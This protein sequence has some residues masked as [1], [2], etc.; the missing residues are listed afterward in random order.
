MVKRLLC[1][2][3]KVSRIAVPEFGT[4]DANSVIG[5]GAGNARARRR[6]HLAKFGG[7]GGV[8]RRAGMQSRGA[9]G[10]H[11]VGVRTCH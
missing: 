5:H 10:A 2:L 3:V 4:R 8:R 7:H 1:A 9:R 6:G 11:G